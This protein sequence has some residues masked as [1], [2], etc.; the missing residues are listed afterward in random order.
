ME[1]V[2]FIKPKDLLVIE[3]ENE[4]ILRKGFLH[5]NEVTINKEKSSKEFNSS[6]SIFVQENS[7]I[8]NKN[9]K[10]YEDFHQLVQFRLIDLKSN[11]KIAD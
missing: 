6:F 8:L 7:I 4:Y 9:D 10:V 3:N 2:K 11:E 5:S 1:Q